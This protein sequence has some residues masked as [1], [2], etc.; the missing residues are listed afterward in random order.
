MLVPECVQ[1][2]VD[3][4]LEFQDLHPTCRGS[5]RFVSYE[6]DVVAFVNSGDWWHPLSCGTFNM[7]LEAARLAAVVDQQV[8]VSRASWL[9]PYKDAFIG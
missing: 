6:G 5:A 7:W 8:R 1:W 4:R 3:W 9:S 2:C